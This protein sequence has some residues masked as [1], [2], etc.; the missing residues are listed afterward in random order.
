VASPN[1]N[2][3]F[4]PS[5]RQVEYLILFTLVVDDFS[6]VSTT[7]RQTPLS[8]FYSWGCTMD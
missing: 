8:Y 7:M 2:V 1:T 3:I 5:V 6:E 4:L